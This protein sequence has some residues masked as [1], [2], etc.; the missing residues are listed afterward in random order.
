MVGIVRMF[1]LLPH[2][3]YTH[4]ARNSNEF[5]PRVRGQNILMIPTILTSRGFSSARLPAPK[6]TGPDDA[7]DPRAAG[8]KGGG[9]KKR[10]RR[11]R[12]SAGS[13]FHAG[14]KPFWALPDAAGVLPASGPTGRPIPPGRH[15]TRPAPDAGRPA[16]IPGRHAFQS[17]GD[18]PTMPARNCARWRAAIA[19]AVQTPHR[20]AHAR[21]RR[22]EAP[23]ARR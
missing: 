1:Q 20:A 13:F 17:R 15:P 12:P 21:M 6:A 9:R 3:P 7:P 8:P 4:D 19:A 16:A 10:E 11:S 2:G 18:V 23:C 14:P 5:A 22:P